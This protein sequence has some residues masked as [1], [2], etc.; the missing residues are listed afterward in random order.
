[1]S[2]L[3]A[4]LYDTYEEHLQVVELLFK[5][6]G[7]KSTFSGQITTVKTHE[8]NTQVLEILEQYGKGR[9]L[10]VDGGGSLYCALL[11]DQLATLAKKNSWSG[12]I[13]FGCIRD[14]ATIKTIEIGV[15]ALGTN[16]RKSIKQGRGIRDIPISFGGVIFRPDMYAYADE[17]GIV[18]AEKELT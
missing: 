13:I 5:D 18:V 7:G 12:I 1:M 14:V 15:K 9:I 17:D 6:Y 8:D 16:P 4:D 3:T 10:V 11:G 2:Y